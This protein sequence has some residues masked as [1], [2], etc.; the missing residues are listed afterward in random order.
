MGAGQEPRRPCLMMIR[1]PGILHTMIAGADYAIRMPCGCW[2]TK[3][4]PRF[5]APWGAA[6]DVILTLWVPYRRLVKVGI[7]ATGSR[8]RAATPPA[9]ESRNDAVAQDDGI[10]TR[11]HALVLDLLV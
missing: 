1:L 10:R 5:D 2:R 6:F 3:G 7:N 8:T 4:P 9:R 11:E